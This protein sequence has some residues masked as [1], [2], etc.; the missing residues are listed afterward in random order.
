MT[1]AA[2]R[3][4]QTLAQWGGALGAPDGWKARDRR[5]A[6]VEAA[7]AWCLGLRPGRDVVLVLSRTEA[8]ALELAANEMLTLGILTKKRRSM[9]A[10]AKKLA[11]ARLGPA[12]GYPPDRAERFEQPVEAIEPVC[13]RCRMNPARVCMGC[14]T[15]A[16]DLQAPDISRRRFGPKHP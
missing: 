6:A 15:F 13:E 10:A 14:A 2:I 16:S 7:I 9:Q 8:W 3:G 5:W 11:A 12:C 1:K 4:L